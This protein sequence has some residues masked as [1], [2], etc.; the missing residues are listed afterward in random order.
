MQ[1]EV[2]KRNKRLKVCECLGTKIGDYLIANYA[3]KNKISSHHE[4]A[5]FGN[6]INN[7]YS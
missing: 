1:V 3:P 4:L 6:V 7:E 2:L 5:G